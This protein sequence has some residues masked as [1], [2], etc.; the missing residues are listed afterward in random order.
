MTCHVSLDAERAGLT[1]SFCAVITMILKRGVALAM[2]SAG[3]ATALSYSTP[4]S[5]LSNLVYMG[6]IFVI[7]PH[8]QGDLQSDKAAN[9][10]SCLDCQGTSV[11]R[12]KADTLET[13]YHV[14]STGE[15]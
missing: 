3:K 2:V 6:H 13:W 9:R 7:S 4:N 1:S 8:D 15:A 12:R 11:A 10:Q 5:W 14:T